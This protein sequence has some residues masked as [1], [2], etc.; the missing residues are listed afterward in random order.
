M[1]EWLFE[2]IFDP[3][4][5]VIT[6]DSILHLQ[7]V[8][9]QLFHSEYRP[10]RQNTLHKCPPGISIHLRLTLPHSDL[11]YIPGF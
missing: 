7:A 4:R 3:M 1:M 5:C 11:N 9:C 2:H 10:I 8:P 6:C